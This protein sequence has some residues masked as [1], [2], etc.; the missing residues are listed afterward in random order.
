MQWS[1]LEN[2]GLEVEVA[3]CGLTSV[4]H[5]DEEQDDEDEERL[6]QSVAAI[7]MVDNKAEE[8]Q[9]EAEQ[10]NFFL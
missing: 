10:P 4:S 1:F 8:E 3:S 5:K 6:G 7:S 2:N 9:T